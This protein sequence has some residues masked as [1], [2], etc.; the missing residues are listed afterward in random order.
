MVSHIFG[1]KQNQLL[2]ELPPIV[3]NSG[4]VSE[5]KMWNSECVAKTLRI[6]LRLTTNHYFYTE[7]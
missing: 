7:I 3:Y 4:I 1:G 2:L 5:K 6:N